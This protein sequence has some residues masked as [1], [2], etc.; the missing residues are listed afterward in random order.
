MPDEVPCVFL[1]MKTLILFALLCQTVVSYFHWRCDWWGAAKLKNHGHV[2]S[3][4][5]NSFVQCVNFCF[6]CLFHLQSKQIRLVIYGLV[7][8]CNESDGFFIWKVSPCRN[9]FCLDSVKKKR[10]ELSDIY[11]CLHKWKLQIKALFIERHTASIRLRGHWMTANMLAF[12]C[13]RAAF[14][15]PYYRYSFSFYPWK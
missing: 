13:W 12:F 8:L 4:Y 5:H 7:A 14:F 1:H 11:E 3:S 6:C 9:L 2:F 15:P 10:K